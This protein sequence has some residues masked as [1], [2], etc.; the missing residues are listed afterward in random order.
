MTEVSERSKALLKLLIERYLREGLPVG[1][2]T[3]AEDSFLSLSPATIRNIMSDLEDRGLIT[4][5][6]TSAGRIPTELG[7]KFF[8]NQLLTFEP[9]KAAEISRLQ[10]ELDALGDIKT[11]MGSTSQLLSQFTQLV[12]IVSTPLHEQQILRLIEFLPLSNQRILVILVLN[13]QAVQNRVIQTPKEYNKSELEQVANYLNAM[14]VGKDLLEIRKHLVKLLQEEREHL[15]RLMR[16]AIE[17]AD[18]AFEGDLSG[19][20]Y[21]VAGESN[22][23][24]LGEPVL[25]HQLRK[26][27]EAFTQKQ[28]ILQVLDLCIKASG[29]QIFIGEEVGELKLKGYSLVSA[30]YSVEGQVLGALGVIGP[31]RMPYE[32]VI[33]I[34]DMTAKFLS[35]ALNYPLNSD[36]GIPT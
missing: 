31:M 9:P 3:L 19:H 26:I 6:H 15:D 24:A 27:F 14:F 25:T 13:E 34:V 4:S 16:T 18:K 12:G 20:D 8:V 21:V 28:D 7:L 11:L 5:P 23:L 29:V 35:A 36:R 30:P 22:L 33:P 17:I 1:S 10:K 2:K 32:R